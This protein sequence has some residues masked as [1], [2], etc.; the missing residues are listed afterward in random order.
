[1]QIE[2][3]LKVCLGSLPVQF[4]GK[5]MLW[6]GLKETTKNYVKNGRKTKM[7]GK[8]IVFIMGFIMGTLFGTV[9][10]RFLI[11]QLLNYIKVKGG[12]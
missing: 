6:N 11:E 10:G 5:D 7:I 1:M 8:I 2:L 3:I 12:F 4:V 9:L